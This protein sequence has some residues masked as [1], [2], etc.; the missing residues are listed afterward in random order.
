M[1]KTL[2]AGL[3]QLDPGESLSG[4]G[5]SFQQINPA[6]TDRFLELGAVTHRH[7]AAEPLANPTDEL[8]ATVLATG[9]AIPSETTVYIGFTLLDGDG[10]ETTMSPAIAVTAE[11]GLPDPED[12]PTASAS[13]A[14]GSL[15]VDTYYYAVSVT[16]GVGGETLASPAI[17]VEREPGYASG[18]IILSGLDDLVAAS[19]G[20][21]WKVYRA[22]GG[23]LFEMME[24]GD[25]ATW[26][27]DGSECADCSTRPPTVNST[28]RVN[29]IVV[30]VAS[31]SVGAADGYR[32]YM[33]LDGSFI[34][35]CLAGEYP[36]GSAG[37]DIAFTTIDVDDGAPPDV[38]TSVRGASKI[39]PDTEL[40]DW[41]W[42]RPVASSGLLPIGSGTA[43]GDVRVVIDETE[44]YTWVASGAAW[45]P[46][47]AA[48]GG[49]G[50]GGG[51]SFGDWTT[52]TVDPGLDGGIVYYRASEDMLLL[53]GTVQTTETWTLA[54]GS[55]WGQGSQFFPIFATPPEWPPGAASHAIVEIRVGDEGSI[56]VP[57]LIAD[58]GDG[59]V[60]VQFTIPGP[61]T[62]VATISAYVAVYMFGTTAPA[63][64]PF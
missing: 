13:Y 20:V 49:G 40:L 38:S 59:N 7:N 25:S 55:T 39:D 1:R 10:G 48:G 8:V 34:S 3:T 46:I 9:G 33:S 4:D 15:R 27:D 56:Y 51:S 2:F 44:M 16:D 62:P 61:N 64:L 60:Y 47:S 63:T 29:Q 36:A 11:P 41:H 21:A 54:S 31:G 50:G 58:I 53:Y 35:P 52:A 45:V 28:S 37:V 17:D 57:A 19:S 23:G 30:N 6:R 14:A 24:T 5:Y 32:I 42:K 12:A 43:D 26:T 18:Q 22:T